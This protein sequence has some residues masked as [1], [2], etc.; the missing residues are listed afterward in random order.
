[1]DPALS[2]ALEPVLHDLRSHSLTEPDI[3]DR[4]WTGVPEHPSAMLWSPDGSGTGVYVNR[5]E[6]V[7]AQIAS[8]AGEVQEW[9][10]EE[11]RGER[12]ATNWPP[13][14]HHPGSHPLNAVVRNQAAVW[15]CPV[16]QSAVAVI[17]TL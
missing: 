5:E 10:I 8:V 15:I 2:E 11:L 16:Q 9:V 4:D 12:S 7:F 6:P 13:C 3:E 1:M 17:G 14:P